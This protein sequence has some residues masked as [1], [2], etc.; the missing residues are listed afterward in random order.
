MAV[1]FPC[2]SSLFHRNIIP[3]PQ[4]PIKIWN[5]YKFFASKAPRSDPKL[6]VR[7]TKEMM[8]NLLDCVDLS[9]HEAER[10][11]ELLLRD[12]NQALISAFLVLLRAKGET[13]EE[14]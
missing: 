14:G 4:V 12:G 7:S 2:T 11:L 10:S 3:S 5:N 1:S 6:P 13:Y 9:E 8:E